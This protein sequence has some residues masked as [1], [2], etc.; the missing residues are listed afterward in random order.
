MCK[1]CQY[2]PENLHSS[3]LYTQLYTKAVDGFYTFWI[4][5]SI[6]ETVDLA[7]FSGTKVCKIK[8]CSELYVKSIQ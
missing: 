2:V 5:L 4:P 3:H 7:L 8:T 6:S 1:N